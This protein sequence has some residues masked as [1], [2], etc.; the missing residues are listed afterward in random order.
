[1]RFAVAQNDTAE[2]EKQALALAALSPDEPTMALAAVGVL[3]STSHDAE[4]KQLFDKVYQGLQHDLDQAPEDPRQLNNLAWICAVAHEHLEDAL[5]AAKR[6]TELD[7]ND[8]NI[9]DTLAEVHFQRGERDEAIQCIRRAIELEPA[10][11]YF[12]TQM[13]RFEKSG[14]D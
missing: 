4:A 11:D 14:K 5:T 3:K 2:A 6:A 9:L 13:K 12:K 1:M 8:A 7:P 10:N